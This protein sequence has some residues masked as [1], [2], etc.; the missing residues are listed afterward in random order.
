MNIRYKKYWISGSILLLL[1][2]L[3]I[4]ISLTLLNEDWLKAQVE[5]YVHEKYKADINIG[6]LEFSPWKGHALLSDITLNR[7]EHDSKVAASIKFIEMDVQIIPLIF[8]DIV[9]DKLLISQPH[10][11][12][13]VQRKPETIPDDT[14]TRLQKLMFIV[15]FELLIHPLLDAVTEIMEISFGDIDRK[16]I[17]KE[18][19][20]NEGIINYK[21]KRVG[22]KPFALD[23]REL[24]YSSK[25]INAKM[26]L[27]F[28][29]NSDI[30]A[31]IFLG[32]TQ[33][34]FSL[35]FSQKPINLSISDIDLGYLDRYLKQKDIL[36]INNG[37]ANVNFLVNDKTVLAK[38]ALQELEL[39]Q[40]TESVRKDF[41]F[42][43]AERLINYVNQADRN[44]NLEFKL[45]KSVIHTSRDLEFCVIEAWEGMWKQILKK[46]SSEKLKQLKEKGTQ[47]LINFFNQKGNE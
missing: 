20:I 24:E 27:D 39:L 29:L 13:D 12:V 16:I 15:T 45:E 6:S 32:E 30:T 7:N 31:K 19:V 9:I 33:A 17:I 25:N 22:S 35:H 28:A 21:A 8:R 41:A 10:L 3:W 43:P 1:I 46:V 34:E 38:V 36:Q 5:T 23:L 14:L 11:K 44:L 37:K 2:V 40:N 18:L 26:P 4:T 47:K 42:I